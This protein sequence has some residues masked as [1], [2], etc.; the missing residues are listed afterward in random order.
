VPKLL[1]V[2]SIDSFHVYGDPGPKAAEALAGIGAEILPF[3]HGLGR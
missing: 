2:S 3:W 1:D